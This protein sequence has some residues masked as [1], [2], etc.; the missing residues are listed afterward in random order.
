MTGR[1]S[2]RPAGGL[3]RLGLEPQPVD[4]IR[5]MVFVQVRQDLGVTVRAEGVPPVDQVAT[6]FTVVVDLAVEHHGDGA[7]F[8][9]DRLRPAG[10]VDDAEAAHAEAHN[11]VPPVPVLVGTAMDHRVT[12]RGRGSR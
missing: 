3:R 6:Q 9:R 1:R 10:Q 12:H 11:A 7:V 2:T 8:I 4:Q 5:T